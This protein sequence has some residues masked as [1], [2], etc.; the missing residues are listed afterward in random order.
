MTIKKAIQLAIEGGYENSGWGYEK[1][2]LDP[3]FWQS[4]GKAK[5]WKGACGHC[6]APTIQTC[7]R[8]MFCEEAEVIDRWKAE[9]HSLIDHLADGGTI[10]SFFKELE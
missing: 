6:L 8:Y 1:D 10:E 9:W 2:F 3:S 7:L 4:L 5:D